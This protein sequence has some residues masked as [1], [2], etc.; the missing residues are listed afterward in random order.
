[1]GECHLPP[2]KSNLNF[3]KFH[4]QIFDF[5]IKILYNNYRVKVSPKANLNHIPLSLEASI[6]AFGQAMGATF[7]IVVLIAECCHFYNKS[8]I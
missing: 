3:N 2:Q 1:M 5:S 4:N 6:A 7:F 8:T